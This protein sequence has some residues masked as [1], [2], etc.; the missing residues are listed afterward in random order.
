M[1]ASLM[2]PD[3][4]LTPKTVRGDFHSWGNVNR[5]YSH[6]LPTHT[7]IHGLC[8]HCFRLECPYIITMQLS[9]LKKSGFT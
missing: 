6:Y 9:V 3:W 4:N 7:H 2:G 5:A 8:S 1:A